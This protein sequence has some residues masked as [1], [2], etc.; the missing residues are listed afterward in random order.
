MYIPVRAPALTASDEIRHIKIFSRAFEASMASKI[1][2][3]VLLGRVLVCYGR[4][5]V[6]RAASRISRRGSA[7]RPQ[8]VAPSGTLK[9]RESAFIR[10]T[11]SVPLTF[12]ENTDG[13]QASQWSQELGGVWLSNLP[14]P[15]EPG[16]AACCMPAS[17]FSHRIE[18][19]LAVR[20]AH[21]NTHA[22]PKAEDCSPR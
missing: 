2:R 15:L 13:G 11:E 4:S 22:C 9:R 10:R 20:V 16:G 19:I 21:T 17:L 6:C 3:R 14:T 5:A 18:L 1:R 7:A 8:R 12:L